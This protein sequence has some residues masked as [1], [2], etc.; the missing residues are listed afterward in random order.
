VTR[1]AAKLRRAAGRAA[2]VAP[3]VALLG[4]DVLLRRHSYGALFGV[5]FVT[6]WA[7]TFL[8][9]SLLLVA[10]ARRRG[11]G[12][13]LARGGAA[14]LAALAGFQ[15]CA[16][17][18]FDTYVT[19]GILRGA[20]LLPGMRALAK[21]F[22]GTIAAW[23][24]VPAIGAAALGL[25]LAR[26][27]PSRRSAARHALWASALLVVATAA[28]TSYVTAEP[29]AAS[30]DTLA[31]GALGRFALERPTRF[32]APDS[33]WHRDVMPDRVPPTMPR[34]ERRGPARN[35]LL[36]ITE[37]VRAD[38]ICIGHGADC[39][40]NPFS[41]AVVPDR[42]PLE[43]MRAVDSFTQLS[44]GV[45]LTGLPVDASR[46]RWLTAPILFDYAHA[47]GV[48]TAYWSAQHPAF[49]RMSAWT[50]K[51]PIDRLAWATDF[52]PA[53]D[54]VL[55][56]DDGV[57]TRRAIEELPTLPEPFFAVVH[58]CGTHFPYRIDERDAPFQ[59][60]SSKI[61]RRDMTPLR[62]RYDDAIRRQDRYTAELLRALRAMPAGGRTVVVFLS[63]HGES[64][65]EHDAVL[66]GSSLWDPELRVPAWV[67]APAGTLSTD[68]RASLRALADVPV[69][70]LDVAPTVLDLLGVLDSPA[71]SWFLGGMAGASL[72]RHPAR[73][74]PVTISTCDEL[75]PCFIPSRGR[76][77]GDLKQVIRPPD[78]VFRCF[79]TRADPDELHDLGAA[80]CGPAP[81]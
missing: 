33:K 81:P 24:A 69:T 19:Y 16:F 39:P 61:D 5:P 6:T 79:D 47:A 53:A 37:S 76:L 11:L 80:V 75:W 71:W 50:N 35:V 17:V 68:E 7:L 22:V 78:D 4:V 30:P 10:G 58:Y 70:Q 18:H 52:D 31:L 41:N 38:A 20:W 44:F 36:V 29:L 45:I 56:A 65:F 34:V 51:A 25:V 55:G 3:P 73:D 63:D 59:P 28:G 62:N 60:Q 40:R 13:W 12:R 49:A 26:R 32:R 54:E 42:L 2:V 8:C 74:R 67:D 23:T 1:R 46:T 66:H 15:V 77:R 57:V 43:R 64:F 48:A 9:W 72:L 14:L 27:A 21:P